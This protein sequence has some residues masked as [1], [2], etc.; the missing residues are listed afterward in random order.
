MYESGFFNNFLFVLQVSH[1]YSS[2]FPVSFVWL[3]LWWSAGRWLRGAIFSFSLC[4]GDSCWRASFSS[5]HPSLLPAWMCWDPEGICSPF[6]WVAN[7][8]FLFARSDNLE[9]KRRSLG[10]FIPRKRA[11]RFFC[12]NTWSL[13]W[14][15]L[16]YGLNCVPPRWLPQIHMLKP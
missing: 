7:D 12:L 16:C 13:F 14:L 4:S 15:Y 1:S 6:W 8:P 3:T 11:L 10:F 9:S 2:C 5:T